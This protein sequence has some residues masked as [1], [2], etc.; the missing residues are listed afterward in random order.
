MRRLLKDTVGYGGCKMMRRQLGIAHVEDIECIED[1]KQ[2]AVAESL[3]L[4][5][6]ARF[7]T[8]RHR[9]EDIDDMVDIVRTTRKPRAASG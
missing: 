4:A 9:V 5:I 7:I 1:P 6:G 3:A 2:R 8:E